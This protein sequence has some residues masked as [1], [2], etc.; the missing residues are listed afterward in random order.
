MKKQKLTPKQEN[1]AQR[2]VQCGNASQ[3]YRD[4]YSVGAATKMATVNR[5]AKELLDNGKIAARIKELQDRGQRKHDI[6]IETL[7]EMYK[8]AFS[9]GKEIEQPA[10]MNGSATGLAKLHGLITDK[11]QTEV[12][13]AFSF[14]ERLA[15]RKAER[16]ATK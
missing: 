1:F 3:S 6:T 15:R 12:S 13:V 5:K 16:Q 7:T 10:A 2:Y 14:A 9:M 4:T 11:T 8:E